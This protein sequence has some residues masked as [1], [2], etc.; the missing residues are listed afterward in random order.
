LLTCI[1]GLANLDTLGQLIRE[2]VA[3][4]GLIHDGSR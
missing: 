4:S 2:K 3:F 1:A